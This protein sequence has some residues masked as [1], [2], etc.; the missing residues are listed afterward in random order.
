[1]TDFMR[2]AHDY[3]NQLVWWLMCVQNLI[4]RFK[5]II[6]QLNEHYYYMNKYKYIEGNFKHVQK[7]VNN[8][9]L[10]EI[11]DITQKSVTF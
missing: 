1:M 5:Q 3:G 9:F 11:G 6:D 2:P 8:N 4:Q 10:K 7:H